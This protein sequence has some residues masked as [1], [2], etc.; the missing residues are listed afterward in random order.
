[1]IYSLKSKLLGLVDRV[2][3]R[4]D[5][6]EPLTR[7]LDL[8]V[9]EQDS[10]DRLERLAEYYESDLRKYTFD[11]GT[12]Y[13]HMVP[14]DLGDM[15]IWQGVYAA[16]CAR[17]EQAA[18]PDASHRSATEKAVFGLMLFV[19]DR[20]V[21][22]V[23][24][25]EYVGQG[26]PFVIDTSKP[27]QY[28][29]DGDLLFKDDASLDSLAGWLYGVATA[30]SL[31]MTTQEQRNAIARYCQQFIKD[32][33]RLR[34]RDNSPTRF[35][36]CRPGFFQAPVRTLATVTILRMGELLTGSDFGWRKM[37]RRFSAEFARTETHVPGRV[38]WENANLAVLINSAYAMVAPEAAPGGREARDGLRNLLR[39]ERAWG[40]AFL[41]NQCRA[42]GIE[43]PAEQLRVADKILREFPLG[44]GNPKIPAV[45]K[46]EG[47]SIK[48]SGERCAR[49]ALPPWRRPP[50]DFVWQRN[51]F[52]LDGGTEARY[53]GLDLLIAYYLVRKP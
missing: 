5:P 17:R 20:L 36:D 19:N 38:D 24:P 53:N 39:K 49:Q 32:R 4:V 30:I 13:T 43:V 8:P 21:R 27:D 45:V 31:D 14:N 25:H 29:H 33:Y 6:F 18:G 1:M 42:L 51:P 2:N 11:R 46:G 44:P 9:G 40:N 52:V 41:V 26:K 48:V 28:W 34:N 23:I 37:A 22:G 12:F 16:M 35:G 7:P 47:P 15:C 3:A 10:P 50:A